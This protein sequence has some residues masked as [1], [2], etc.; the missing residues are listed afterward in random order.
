M[1]ECVNR[2]DPS[3]GA[4]RHPLP[5][6]EGVNFGCFALPPTRRTNV[7]FFSLSPG[8]RVPDRAGEGFFAASVSLFDL[9]GLRN[10]FLIQE[11]LL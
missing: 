4:A 10:P 2:K 6:G 9:F 3:P 8:E 5:S 7:I 1:P 11:H